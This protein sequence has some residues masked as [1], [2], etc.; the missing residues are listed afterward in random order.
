MP[1][2]VIVSAPVFESERELG[3]RRFYVVTLVSV[4]GSHVSDRAMA[5]SLPLH[6]RGSGRTTPRL[7]SSRN[8]ARP[9]RR[10]CPSQPSCIR[11]LEHAGRRGGMAWLSELSRNQSAPLCEKGRQ[12]RRRLRSRVRPSAPSRL[13]GASLVQRA[14]FGCAHG[15]SRR[16]SRR[17]HHRRARTAHCG[18]YQLP[19]GYHLDEC[20]S[21]HGRQ[22]RTSLQ[23][24]SVGLRQ[25]P[26]RKTRHLRSASPGLGRLPRRLLGS[27]LGL[28]GRLRPRVVVPR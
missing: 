27:R 18:R 7:L 13:D 23:G 20:V 1:A 3:P 12:A 15:I 26:S 6:L 25:E 17:C 24:T 8:G 21:S 9:T 22:H 10:A 2:L 19:S 28:V 4:R 16:H 14:L 5:P 11:L